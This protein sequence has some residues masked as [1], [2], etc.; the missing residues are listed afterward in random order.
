M[1]HEIPADVWTKVEMFVA[2]GGYASEADVLRDA[3]SALERANAEITAIRE[4]IEDME[5]GRVRPFEEFDA[6]FRK[7]HG[8]PLES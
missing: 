4:G 8:I 1:S 7:Q 5:A 6:E 2:T 3:L